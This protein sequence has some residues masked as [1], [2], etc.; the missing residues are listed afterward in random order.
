MANTPD[1]SRTK[2][3]KSS[4]SAGNGGQC[5]EWAPEFAATGAVPVRDSK[6]PDGP[7][8]VIAAPAW[9]AFVTALAEGAPL[10]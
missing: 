5:V 4:Y 10:A 8:L 1:L 3:V 7:A 2:W 6:N 9:K